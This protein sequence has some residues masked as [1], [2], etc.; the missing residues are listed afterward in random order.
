MR[1]II[2]MVHVGALPGTPKAVLAPGEL[3]AAAVH[4]AREL[5][6]AGFDAVII[7]NMHDRPYLRDGIGPEVT[8]C[9]AAAAAA[10]RAAVEV[11]I[12]IQ[13]LGG[14]ACEALAVAHATGLDFVRCENFVFAHVADE[15][16][17]GRAVAGPLLRYRRQIGAE[18]I[19]IVA[20]IKKKH[21]SHALTADLDIAACA[22]AAEFFLADA[23]VVTGTETGSPVSMDDLRS[24][25]AATRL[26]V[27]VGS[28]AD[29]QHAPELLAVADAV[30]VGSWVKAGGDWAQPV[31]PERAAAFVRAAKAARTPHPTTPGMD[32]VRSLFARR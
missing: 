13:V 19:A 28:G 3:V 20:D 11:P 23:V 21:A 31:D 10:V 16:L 24:A 1:G 29:P 14:G 27:L 17:M 32:A 15:G 2:G 4:E 25:R 18:R 12:G 5:A 7:E 8:A 26:P 22:R 9:M 6:R 30:I